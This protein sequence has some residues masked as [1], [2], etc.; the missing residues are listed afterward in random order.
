D[1]KNIEG[2]Y[3]FCTKTDVELHCKY[4]SL[5]TTKCIECQDAFNM[6]DGVCAEQF[7]DLNKVNDTKMSVINMKSSPKSQ[8]E[9]DCSTRNNKGCQRCPFGY[10]LNKNGCEKCTNDCLSCYNATYC[11]SCHSRY[12]LDLF[13]KCQTL[14]ELANRCEVPLPAGG[15]CAIC[16][17]GYFK[18][19]KDCDV[20]D[21]SCDMCLKKDECLSCKDGYIKIASVTNYVHQIQHS[22]IGVYFVMILIIY[23]MG[24]VLIVKRVVQH[25]KI[26]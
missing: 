25:V 11:I 22:Q 6:K 1:T 17:V 7:D 13:M 2:K 19:E 23:K 10:F 24:V 15:R 12:F 16:K 20:C 9:V 4:Y 26:V 5:N 18:A 14:G 8:E 21:E 3:D